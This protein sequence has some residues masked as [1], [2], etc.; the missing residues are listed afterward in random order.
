VPFVTFVD[1][2]DFLLRVLD[3]EWREWANCKTFYYLL[4]TIL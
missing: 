4:L 2:R 1:I 3:H